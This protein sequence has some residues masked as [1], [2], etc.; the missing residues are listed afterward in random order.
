M[1]AWKGIV[2]RSFTP[3]QFAQYVETLYFSTWRPRFVVLHN[4]GAPTLQQWLSGHTSPQQRILNLEHYY[5][6]EKHWSAGP[7]LFID[8]HHIWAFTPLIVPGVHSPSWNPISWGVEM[9]GD[10]AREDFDEG[11]GA[12]VKA[13][14]VRALAT[15]H[16]LIGLDPAGLKLH[17]EDELTTHN[18]PGANVDKG[19]MIRL[20]R[21][22]M[23][24]DHPAGEIPIS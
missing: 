12:A 11:P 4:T 18:C 7:H 20:I 14:T 24:G 8:N 9:V 15:L 22:E 17:K 21:E 23:G 1:P 13:N 3:D 2:N 6:D 19:E 16:M 5:R 10:Y